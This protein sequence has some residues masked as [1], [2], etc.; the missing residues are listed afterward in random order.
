METGAAQAR[1]GGQPSGT[2]SADHH[3]SHPTILMR[4]PTDGNRTC[5]GDMLSER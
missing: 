5:P 4:D 2:G 1:R 3:M